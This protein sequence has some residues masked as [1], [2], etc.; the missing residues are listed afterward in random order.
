MSFWDFSLENTGRTQIVS[1]QYQ[2]QYGRAKKPVFM[3]V[4][5]VSSVIPTQY[6][7]EQVVTDTYSQAIVRDSSTKVVENFIYYF[8]NSTLVNALTNQTIPITSS[9]TENVARPLLGDESKYVYSHTERTDFTLAELG[10]VG[11]VAAI[12]AIVPGVAP[13]VI[14]NIVAYAVANKLH[15]LYIIQKVYKYWEKEDGDNYL[16]L[17]QVTSIYSKTDDSLVGGPWTNYNKF[18][19]R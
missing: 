2:E 15:G 14:G 9:G 5:A 3:R 19:Q 11:I 1:I 12:V 6:T 4:F 18:R 7:I 16:Y 13:S 10:T 17:K 8:D